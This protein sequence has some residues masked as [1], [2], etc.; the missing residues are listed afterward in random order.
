MRKPKRYIEPLL[1]SAEEVG[2][3]IGFGRSTVY[4]M[5]RSGEIPSIQV[6]GRKRVRRES[7]DA[8]I[9]SQSKSQQR[10]DPM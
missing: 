5:L 10:P 2:R 1:Y 4:E 3:L 6:V 9:E 7:L 8:W